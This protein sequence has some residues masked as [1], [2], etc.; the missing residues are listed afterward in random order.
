MTDIPENFR[1]RRMAVELVNVLCALAVGTDGD[2]VSQVFAQ[3]SMSFNRMNG[4]LGSVVEKV[5][6]SRDREE[7]L[8]VLWSSLI[9][10][11]VDRVRQLLAILRERRVLQVAR[12]GLVTEYAGPDGQLLIT[13]MKEY[14][15]SLRGPTAEV[16]SIGE[17]ITLAEAAVGRGAPF[18]HHVF[19]PD[20]LYNDTRGYWTIP[21][22]IVSDSGEGIIIAS[23][24]KEKPSEEALNRLEALSV[25]SRSRSSGAEPCDG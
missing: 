13:L 20:C 17:L 16:Q 1:L 5:P 19:S 6:F 25:A 15:V 9:G 10:I 4:F 22:E 23:V 18:H 24:S 3:A 8:V 2:P 12:A 7:D 11:P 21:I 14:L